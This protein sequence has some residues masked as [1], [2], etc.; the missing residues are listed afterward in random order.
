MSPFSFSWIFNFESTSSSVGA[1]IR[2]DS[3]VT[4]QSLPLCEIVVSI[5]MINVKLKWGLKRGPR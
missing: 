5:C 2:K 1:E 4:T 3:F